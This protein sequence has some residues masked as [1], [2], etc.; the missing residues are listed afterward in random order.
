MMRFMN[1]FQSNRALSLQQ[2]HRLKQMGATVR[3]AS[4]Y[5]EKLKLNEEREILA[6]VE[7]EKMEI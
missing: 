5:M 2:E 1:L 3:N 7:M 4:S 6:R